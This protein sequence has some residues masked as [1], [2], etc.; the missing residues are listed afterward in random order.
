MCTHVCHKKQQTTVYTQ[1]ETV[2]PDLYSPVLLFH[3]YYIYT[4][5]LIWIFKNNFFTL[6]WLTYM[7]YVPLHVPTV[8]G[9]ARNAWKSLVDEK[10]SSRGT[11]KEVHYQVPVTST[12]YRLYV[13]TWY[14]LLVVISIYHNLAVSTLKKWITINNKQKRW[15]PV[16]HKWQRTTLT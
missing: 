10:I 16:L 11:F 14:I 9:T 5:Q 12:W 13:G 15:D 2:I 7:T 6:T 8:N 1:L 4:Q 3:V